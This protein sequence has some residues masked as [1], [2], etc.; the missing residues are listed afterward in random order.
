MAPVSFTVPCSVPGIISAPVVLGAG[1]GES[2][3]GTW[4]A[5]VVPASLLGDGNVR[6]TL[7]NCWGEVWSDMPEM[8]AVGVI[9][10]MGITGVDCVCVPVGCVL[11]LPVFCSSLEMGEKEGT[12]ETG[13]MEDSGVTVLLVAD[14]CVACVTGVVSGTAGVVGAVGVSAAERRRLARSPMRIRVGDGDCATGEEGVAAGTTGVGCPLF[15]RFW[16]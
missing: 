2:G 5:P 16:L 9:G 4:S 1:K 8:E 6:V 10:D 3:L 13:D 12:V 15:S 7:P 14:M 11:I